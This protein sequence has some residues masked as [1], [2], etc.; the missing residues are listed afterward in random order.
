LNLLRL[1]T[2]VQK[3][4]ELEVVGCYLGVTDNAI[5]PGD[6]PTALMWA[7]KVDFFGVPHPNC[8][9][10]IPAHRCSF[11]FDFG[12]MSFP[13]YHSEQVRFGLNIANEASL[14][15]P[16]DAQVI[17][18]GPG[19]FYLSVERHTRAVDVRSWDEAKPT[20]VMTL[21]PVNSERSIVQEVRLRPDKTRATA[22]KS[23]YWTLD[24]AQDG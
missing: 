11:S 5:N 16:S 9:V 17:L 15:L 12:G 14:V 3:L 18:K 10:V 1:L 8:Q 7:L 24:S 19:R 2:P 4:P 23:A 20:V 22:F 6:R 13:D 21:H